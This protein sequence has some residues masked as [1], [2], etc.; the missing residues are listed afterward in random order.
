M[1]IMSMVP[2]WKRPQK[3]GA[4]ERALEEFRAHHAKLEQNLE[5]PARVKEIMAEINQT[6]TWIDSSLR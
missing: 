6:Q 1:S 5:D 2:A 3:W 4:V